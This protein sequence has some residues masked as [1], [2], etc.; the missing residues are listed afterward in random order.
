MG[1]SVRIA[2]SIDDKI[3]SGLDKIKDRFG[4]MAADMTVGSAAGSLAVKG[5][6]KGFD[7]AGQAIGRATQLVGDS[8]DAYRTEQA[9][10]AGLNAALDTNITNWDHNTTAIESTLAAREKLAFADDAQ[11]EALK[12]LVAAT[13][14]SSDALEAQA[15]AM[16]LARF[17]GIDLSTASDLVA[18]A[19]NGNTTSLKKLGIQ[20]EAGTS[21]MAALS[22]ITK[23]AGGSARAYAETDLGKVEAANIAVD[24]SMEKLGRSFSQVGAVV[25]PAL[26]DAADKVASRVDLAARGIEYLTTKSEKS[27]PVMQGLG[28]ILD[29]LGNYFDHGAGAIMDRYAPA[30]D[31]AT[32]KT[33]E[34]EA[35]AKTASEA[36]ARWA[37]SVGEAAVGVEDG[38]RRV[39]VATAGISGDM[40]VGFVDSSLSAA[41]AFVDSMDRVKGS[42]GDARDAIKGAVDSVIN[43]TWDPLINAAEITATKLELADA[44]KEASSKDLT[45][46]EKAQLD[47]RV[48]N[49]QK[50]LDKMLAE[51]AQYG[52]DAAVMGYADGK[53]TK[54]QVLAGLQAVDPAVRQHWEDYVKAQDAAHQAAAGSAY[55]GGTNIGTSLDA[56]IADGIDGAR[57]VAYDKAGDVIA[58]LSGFSANGYPVGYS[59][60]AS[61]ADGILASDY[62]IDGAISRAVGS[63]M[64]GFSPPKAGPLKN[65]DKG[66]RNIAHSWTENFADSIG[67][68]SVD[69]A[70]SDIAGGLTA[71]PPALSGGGGVM[72]GA[73]TTGDI[74]IVVPLTLE[75]R[76][77]ARAVA[78]WN[79]RTGSRS[80]YTPG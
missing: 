55:V 29:G 67:G 54:E 26:A 20:V 31:E 58:T 25:M 33:A 53:Y 62:L 43:D 15:V 64:I 69:R 73:A 3:S 75:G 47:L 78:I 65:I 38:G 70:L 12:I 45:A 48:L 7:L 9:S 42:I 4:I 28:T 6:E 79:G 80:Q 39:H 46:T 74:T 16:D 61:V 11:R 72:S 40:K 52:S 24:D 36:T 76:E 60:G 49:L 22:A 10:I 41:L 19:W 37:A 68:P 17:R 50:S 56:G 44:R 1:N 57:G 18:K 34:A 8:I 13:H 59:W 27:G 14:D 32:K 5:I 2:A 23:V 35:A 51:Q 66:A 63:K 71:P 30:V 21:G 77:V